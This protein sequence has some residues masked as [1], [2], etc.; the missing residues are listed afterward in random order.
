MLDLVPVR[1]RLGAGGVVEIQGRLRSRGRFVKVRVPVVT[2]A[3]RFQAHGLLRQQA[4][5]ALLLLAFHA[6]E[7]PAALGVSALRRLRTRAARHLAGREVF[8]RREG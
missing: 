4:I 2:S 1:V 5:N 6:G 7:R 8:N 3:R